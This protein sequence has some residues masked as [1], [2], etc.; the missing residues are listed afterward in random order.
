M[1]W[2]YLGAFLA[3]MFLVPAVIHALVPRPIVACA[4]SAVV[5]ALLFLGVFWVMQGGEMTL[6]QAAI[7]LLAP[8]PATFLIAAGVGIP[9]E[10]RRN[11]RPPRM[12]G[13]EPRTWID[14][15]EPGI[16]IAALILVILYN[17]LRNDA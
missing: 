5:V 2:L 11:P 14:W 15:I 16:G 7:A 3:P 13:R 4:A 17:I 1:F 10:R 8:M 9:F 6:E 12:F